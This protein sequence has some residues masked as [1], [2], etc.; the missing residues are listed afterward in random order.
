MDL[1]SLKVEGFKRFKQ[2]VTLQ[3]SG[4]L[5]AILG[6]NEAGKTSLLNA[7]LS[8]QNDDPIHPSDISRTCSSDD[9]KIIA[10]F[11]LTEDECNTAQLRYPSWFAIHKYGDGLRRYGVTPRPPIRNIENRAVLRGRLAKAMGTTRFEK[12]SEQDTAAAESFKQAII[13]LESESESLPPSEL[14][15]LLELDNVM[16]ENIVQD[17]DGF[18]SL[19]SDLAKAIEAERKPTPHLAAIGILTPML[20]KILNFGEGERLLKSSY[21]LPEFD[22]D[23]P[24]ALKGLADIAALDLELVTEAMR[25]GSEAKIATLEYQANANL[26]K[27]FEKAWRQSKIHVSFRFATNRI[28]IQIVDEQSVFTDLDERSDGLRQFVALQSFVMRED[29]VKPIL[30]IDELEQK[31]HY[32]AQADLVQMLAKQSVAGKV[33]YTTHSAGCLPEDLGSGV[34]LVSPS[35]TSAS[36]SQIKNK[37]WDGTQTGLS[38]LLYGM[39]ANTLAFFPTRRAV[40]VEGP[41]DMLLLP[42]L[43][44]ETLQRDNIGLQFVPGLANLIQPIIEINSIGENTVCYLIDGDESGDSISSILI[45][46]GVGE[47][48]IFKISNDTRSA[49]ELEDFINP[50]LL[51]DAV[52]KCLKIFH[53]KPPLERSKINSKRRTKQI[54]DLY[55]MISGSDMPKV[56]IA[57]ALLER[58]DSDPTL[59]LLD[60]RRADAFGKLVGRVVTSFGL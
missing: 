58:I 39:G 20:P 30:I 50:S 5:V 7:L 25:Q 24:A 46:G 51:M 13:A 18:K 15:T 47:E 2:N 10:S 34:R 27:Q 1:V 11:L 48:R 36:E 59:A 43:F 35:A 53:N 55:K 42:R 6:P 3:T 52:D 19:P 31:L 26:R 56:S 40:V 8:T 49:V 23:P 14:K 60:H 21:S 22:G 41:S 12:M 44:R 16:S 37:F 54:S 9:V 32:D 28:D 38:P 4:K 33:I 57:Y 45:K 17:W 29:G